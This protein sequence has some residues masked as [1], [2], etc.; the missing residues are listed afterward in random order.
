MKIFNQYLLH[1]YLL[2]L[3][4]NK[5]CSLI[6]MDG[7]KNRKYISFGMFFFFHN[8]SSSNGNSMNYNQIIKNNYW[9]TE[10]IHII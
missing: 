10:L 6:C 3:K 9:T 1:F 8:Q 5:H 2:K 4:Q 7:I